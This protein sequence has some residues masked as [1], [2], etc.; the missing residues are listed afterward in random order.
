M[1]ILKIAAM[2]A[3]LSGAA[4]AQDVQSITFEGSD[5][6]YQ[7]YP[8]SVVRVEDFLGR[9][10]LYI[11][12]NSLTRTELDLGDLVID[13][14]YASSH[15]SGFI[16]VD[17]RVDGASGNLEQFYT[18]PHQSGHP[19][20][21]QYMVMIN[22]VATWQLHAGPNDATA[23]DLPA[24]EWIHVRIV[25]IGD[26]ADIYVGDMETP[27]L[28]VPDLRFD[29]GHG[30]IAVFASDR[31]FVRD[32]G[33]YFSNIEARP[34]T[35]SDRIIGTPRETEPLAEGL[36]STFSV[37]EPL[38]E[39][40]LDGVYSLA[41]LDLDA[42]A[43]TDLDV[44]SDGVANL[45]RTTGLT[46]EANTVFVRTIIDAE[47]ATERLMMFGYS[48][49][50]RLYV[51][52]EQVY[53]GNAGWRSRDHRFLGTVALAPPS[54]ASIRAAMKSSRRFQSPLAGGASR[55]RSKTSRV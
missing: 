9:E 20:A 14:D 35:S 22:G 33:A 3:C 40:D 8:N 7:D 51:N 50:V 48:D 15:P 49:R 6:S 47:A 16:G 13:Y 34:A 38:A 36:I 46:R 53:F 1:R 27:L 41:G 42:R 32:T 18:R 45:A 23:I 37:S 19:D 39:S 12:G 44:E 25:A 52:G 54:C 2:A 17:F 5:W 10:A 21:T 4:Q 55:R 30:P 29:G 26:R 11:S 24:R 31:Y 43:W 28:H